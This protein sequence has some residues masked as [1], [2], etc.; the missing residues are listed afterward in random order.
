MRDERSPLNPV[1]LRAPAL[2]R[3]IPLV[4]AMVLPQE[5]V[6]HEAAFSAERLRHLTIGPRSGRRFSS[7]RTRAKLRPMALILEKL[8]GEQP[9]L[10][11]QGAGSNPASR[12][13]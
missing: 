11:R 6:T 3:L 7:S 10:D 13:T 1:A 5:D 8:S 9:A 2:A 12:S 4:Y